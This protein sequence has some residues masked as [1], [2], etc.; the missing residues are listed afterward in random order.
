[1]KVDNHYVVLTEFGNYY[2]THVRPKTGHG[3][4][5]APAIYNF[6][7]EHELTN[8]PL[9]V[10]GCDGGCVNTGPTKVLF[11]TWR[12][13]SP[14]LCIAASISSTEISSHSGKYLQWQAQRSEEVARNH[15]SAGNRGSV[16]HSCH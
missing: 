3:K 7:V 11:I 2:L 14:G 16:R 1:M 6:L 4:V 10:A 9:Y 12:W 15:W 5:V 13:C 8:Q